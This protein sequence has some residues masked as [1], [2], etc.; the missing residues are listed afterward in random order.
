MI[1]LTQ[2]DGQK[3]GQDSQKHT[4]AH[5][6]S[7]TR[8]PSHCADLHMRV[9]S[10]LLSLARMYSDACSLLQ[11]CTV[12]PRSEGKGAVETSTASQPRIALVY[13]YLPSAILPCT[14]TRPYPLIITAGRPAEAVAEAVVA[15]EDVERA[16]G[17]RREAHHN[18]RRGGRAG[19]GERR[20]RAGGR[21]EAINVVEVDCGWCRGSKGR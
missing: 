4:L 13:L 2:T 21:A 19:G 14:R 18:A 17:R 8:L 16:V 20:P 5:T 6:R 12:E 7:R 1:S 15:P 10:Q 9:R 11:A 3:Y